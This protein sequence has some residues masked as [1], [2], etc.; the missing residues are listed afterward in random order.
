MLITRLHP[1]DPAMRDFGILDTL[2]LSKETYLH[3]QTLMH[4][5]LVFARKLNTRRA[6]QESVDKRAGAAKMSSTLKS[7]HIEKQG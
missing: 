1:T 2:L 4:T 6:R 3:S 7:L 5:E